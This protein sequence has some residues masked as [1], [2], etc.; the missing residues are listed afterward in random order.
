MVI[1]T[2]AEINVKPI[3]DEIDVLNAFGDIVIE[4]GQET[5]RII[6]PQFIEEASYYPARKAQKFQFQTLK[7]QRW[8]FA[9]LAGNI[10]GVTIS[11]DG[12]R[13]KRTG[14]LKE[15][16]FVRVNAS[17]DSFEIVLG[18]D[19]AITKWVM[20]SFDRSRDYQVIGHK[21][22]GWI[23][24]KQTADF[25]LDATEEEFLDRIPQIYAQWDVQRRNR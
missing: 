23:P 16:F 10:P 19:S 6:E 1:R 15:S 7:S 13:Y 21:Q 14:K 22:T 12:K 25:W 9:A 11:T 4:A 24:I 3:Q 2:R 5:A 20:G 17:T 18:S 8:W